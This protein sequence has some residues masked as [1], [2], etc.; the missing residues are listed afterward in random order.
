MTSDMI[1][2]GD[3]L[4]IRTV[5]TATPTLEATGTPTQPL[6][7]STRRPTRTPTMQ[8][9]ASPTLEVSPSPTAEPTRPLIMMGDILGN[10]MLIA[11]VILAVAG[12]VMVVIG[13]VLRRSR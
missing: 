3:R 5:S 11:I 1:Q 7:T 13:S 2:P 4:L 6:P 8:P 12:V 9:P 10:V